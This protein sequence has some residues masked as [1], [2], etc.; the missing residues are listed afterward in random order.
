MGLNPANSRHFI[1]RFLKNG[2][3][4]ASFCLFSFF[5]NPNF[6]AGF[7]LGSFVVE[8][9]HAYHLT[10]PG[11]KLTVFYCQLSIEKRSPLKNPTFRLVWFVFK[12]HWRF[13]VTSP[14]S[15]ELIRSFPSNAWLTQAFQK[16]RHLFLFWFCYFWW[17]QE[18]LIRQKLELKY[19][20]N[21]DRGGSRVV[22]VLP[23]NFDNLSL[24]FNCASKEPK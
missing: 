17:M 7:E 22:I 12:Q 6:T 9:E 5:S 11:L 16:A 8:G 15:V 23:F 3:T 20:Y 24:C 19:L 1:E 2:P 13:R 18:S 4:P 21:R 10:T 14:R